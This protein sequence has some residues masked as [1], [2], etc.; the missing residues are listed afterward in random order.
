MAKNGAKGGGRHGAVKGRSQSYNPK[1]GLYTKRN[2]STGKF[3]DVKTTGG[4]FK[5]VTSEK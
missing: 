5:G 1:T 3:M 2:T 4:K